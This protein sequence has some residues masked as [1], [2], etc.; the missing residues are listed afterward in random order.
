M[1]CIRSNLLLLATASCVLCDAA[2]LRRSG[3]HNRVLQE[4]E[5]GTFL[6]AEIDYHD[7]NEVGMINNSKN[8]LEQT[9]NIQL[10]NGMVYKLNNVNPSWINGKGKSLE[11]GTSKIK[12]GKGATISGANID[13]HGGNPEQVN[14][15][16][17]RNLATGNHR[18][19]AV[20]GT[21][22]VLAVKVSAFTRM[23]DFDS[24]MQLSHF[25]TNYFIVQVVASDGQYGYSEATLSDEVFGTSGDP[26]NLVS[27][28]KACS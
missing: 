23:C 20:T 28:Y 26:V 1:K 3:I 5:T 10:E 12:I 27:Q 24:V 25:F 19:L 22:S 8:R 7:G 17:A 13:L 15:L 21:R 18:E 14:D 4:E 2:T 6:V 16:F 11:S 9:L